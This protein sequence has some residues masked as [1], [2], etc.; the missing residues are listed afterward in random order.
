LENTS[1]TDV[2]ANSGD[3]LDYFVDNLQIQDLQ[4]EINRAGE[5]QRFICGNTHI[6]IHYELAGNI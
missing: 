2:N 3:Q 4:A 1:I 6:H 5:K